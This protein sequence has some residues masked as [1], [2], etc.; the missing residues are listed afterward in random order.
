M[1][2]LKKSLFAVFVASF[3]AF[4]MGTT[5]RKDRSATPEVKSLS[6]QTIH[7]SATVTPSPFITSIIT[8]S[9]RESAQVSRVIDGDTIELTDGMISRLE[10]VINDCWRDIRNLKFEK[11]EDT[12]ENRK[13]T[14]DKCEY[15]D[16]CWG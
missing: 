14:C 4:V 3:I 16:I 11:L 13:N 2:S 15:S 10:E 12:E 5:F 9:V 6:D 8:L 7:P 1:I